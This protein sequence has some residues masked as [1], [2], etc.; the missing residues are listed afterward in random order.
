MDLGALAFEGPHHDV[1][2]QLEIIA[3]PGL[4][5]R[6]LIL[7]LRQSAPIRR[8]GDGIN[9]PA[10]LRLRTAPSSSRLDDDT[11]HPAGGELIPPGP[12]IN[13]C[14]RW[15]S[16]HSWMFARAA[17]AIRSRTPRFPECLTTGHCPA[18]HCHPRPSQA[19]DHEIGGRVDR[20]V[21]ADS[22]RQKTPHA[23]SGRY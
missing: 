20:R 19:A 14:R 23:G 22:R 18:I 2:A 17:G 6:T 11:D 10:C 15:S 4:D 8:H 1:Q 16:R 13:P 3:R 21:R 12:P 7:I 5:R 9:P